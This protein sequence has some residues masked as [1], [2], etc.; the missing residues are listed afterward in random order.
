MVGVGLGLQPGS[1]RPTLTHCLWE[2]CYLR[3]DHRLSQRRALP[4]TS[5]PL[6]LHWQW[7]ISKVLSPT[8]IQYLSLYSL[9]E[10]GARLKRQITACC[11]VDTVVDPTTPHISLF[12]EAFQLSCCLKSL[13]FIKLCW[14][15]RKLS[16]VHPFPRQGK[17]I[18]IY[19]YICMYNH[20]KGREG[21][22][23]AME[24]DY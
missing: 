9:L 22:G 18:C 15:H 7:P 16:A 13:P 14:C 23:V 4:C 12:K 10:A 1:C 8:F 20:S 2:N 3:V 17:Y 19:L 5:H 11:A 24:R 21:S 6:Q